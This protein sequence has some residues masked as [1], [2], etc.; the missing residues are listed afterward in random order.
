MLHL[1]SYPD[2][3]LR[4][5]CL[6]VKSFDP[7]TMR[8]I[9]H[10]MVKIMKE[11]NGI[12]LAAP[13]V[14]I[15]KRFIVCQDNEG[16]NHLMINPVITWTSDDLVIL[17]EGCL[18]YPGLFRL[19]KRPRQVKVKYLTID[20]NTETKQADGWFAR[21]LLHETDHLQGILYTDY[22]NEDIMTKKELK[23]VRDWGLE[24]L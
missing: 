18:S 8:S 7:K 17:K 23:E 20:K 2:P 24:C 3:I 14:G 22:P 6:E 12:G 19:I 21:C 11:E 16:K 9:Y 1:K 5:K 4:E 13:Q 10:D 15:N